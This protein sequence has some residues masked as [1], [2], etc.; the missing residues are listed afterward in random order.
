MCAGFFTGND[1]SNP[2]R[3]APIDNRGRDSRLYRHL[4]GFQ[5]GRLDD[6]QMTELT[7]LLALWLGIG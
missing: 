6:G 2:I 1:R 5:L 4:D 3:L 7:R